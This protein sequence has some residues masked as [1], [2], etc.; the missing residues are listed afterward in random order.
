M[1]K[2]KNE[3][4]A[5][6]LLIFA[7]LVIVVLSAVMESKQITYYS[8]VEDNKFEIC[9]LTIETDKSVCTI[10]DKNK[11]VVSVKKENLRKFLRHWNDKSSLYRLW[12]EPAQLVLEL[13][14]EGTV[15]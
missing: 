12:H 5:W 1:T 10:E 14:K 11:S 13:D 8:T 3:D 9:I 4:S 15:L 2:E 7:I 6:D